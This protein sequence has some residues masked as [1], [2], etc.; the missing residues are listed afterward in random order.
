MSSATAAPD[1]LASTLSLLDWLFQLG[2]DQ[3]YTHAT[4]SAAF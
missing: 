1:V 3:F 4:S 2:R